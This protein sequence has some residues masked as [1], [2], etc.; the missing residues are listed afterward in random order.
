MRYPFTTG[1]SAI[2]YVLLDPHVKPV[3]DEWMAE[4]PLLMPECWV[5]FGS[6]SPEPISETIPC[7]RNG[8]VTFGSLN[9]PYK[10][11]REAIAVWSRIMNEVPNSRFLYVRPE[12]SS[13]VLCN[14]L[15]REFGQHGIGP[16]RL[17][18]VNNWKTGLSHLSYYD[19]ID[20]TLDTFPLVG[21]TTTCDALWMGAPLI[22]K[23]GPSMHQRL[24][25]SVLTNVGLQELCVETDD[26]YVEKAV[27]LANDPESLTLL[28]RELRPALQASA[29]CRSQDYARNFF[30]LMDQLVERHQLR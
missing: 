6:F 11:T 10:V 25:Y 13:L 20:I 5:C 8:M 4:E 3:K 29:L 24:G 7:E 23:Y 26:A 28:R 21:G 14:N 16:E 2:D 30:N 18:F 27:A 15:I 12:L 19:E 9:N 22:T 17:Y 1:I